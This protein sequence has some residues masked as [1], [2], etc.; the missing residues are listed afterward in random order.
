MTS[1]CSISGESQG[2]KSLCKSVTISRVVWVLVAAENCFS[3]SLPD[4]AQPRNDHD[5]P[6][7]L[8]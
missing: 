8:W 3:H 2:R 7:S 4:L 1:S 5:G 6:A